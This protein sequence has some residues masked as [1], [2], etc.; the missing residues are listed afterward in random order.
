MGIA[1]YQATS[2]AF[3]KPAR[4][5]IESFRVEPAT[6]PPLA[7]VT[8]VL[9]FNCYEPAAAVS[10]WIIPCYIAADSPLCHELPDVAGSVRLLGP[11]AEDI[12]AE[13]Y[14]RL[15]RFFSERGVPCAKHAIADD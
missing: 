1:D 2:G 6:A 9:E 3:M 15:A 5:A 11:V 7:A 8:L 14:E 4:D 13:T 10:V 12:G